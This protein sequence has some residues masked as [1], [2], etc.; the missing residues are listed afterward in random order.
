[1]EQLTLIKI[2]PIITLGQIT[3]GGLK[4]YYCTKCHHTINIG[5]DTNEVRCIYCG[6]KN[7]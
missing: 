6:A 4:I 3:S 7:N 2:V 1:M 5:K